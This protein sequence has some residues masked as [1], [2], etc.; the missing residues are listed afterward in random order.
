MAI[1][2]KKRLKNKADKLWYH[3]HLKENCEICGKRANQVHHFFPKGHYAHL[4]HDEDNA[5]SVCQGC[6]MKIHFTGSPEPIQIL[7]KKRGEE[8]YNRL[9]EKSKE[10]PKTLGVG[11]Y[12]AIIE[13]L[14]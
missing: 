4:R 13:E 7:I 14:S 10:R 6:H 9:L 3:K 11:H 2:K 5:I 1:D 8:W 12:E